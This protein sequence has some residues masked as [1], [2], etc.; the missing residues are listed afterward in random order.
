MTGN[1]SLES[2][3]RPKDYPIEQYS[4]GAPASFHGNPRGPERKS[5]H[6]TPHIS[7]EIEEEVLRIT[8]IARSLSNPVG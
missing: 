1:A 2:K 5:S 7:L 4:R 8:P 3:R 6:P